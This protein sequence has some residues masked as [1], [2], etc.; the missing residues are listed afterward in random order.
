MLSRDERYRG[1]YS[2]PLS[3]NRSGQ[4]TITLALHN[5]CDVPLEVHCN[6]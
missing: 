6:Q 4:K 5:T 3:K 1:E 2:G